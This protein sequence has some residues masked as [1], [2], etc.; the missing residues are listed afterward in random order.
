MSGIFEELEM[1][2]EGDK[3]VTRQAIAAATKRFNDNFAGFLRQA[4]T[5]KEFNNRLALVDTDI[6]NMVADVVTEY[7]GDA[8]KI[9]SAVK[10]TV[11]TAFAP[12]T[13]AANE[14][15]M[16]E[17]CGGHGCDKCTNDPEASK[18]ASEDRPEHLEAQDEVQLAEE[19]SQVNPW[20]KK[21]IQDEDQEDGGNLRNKEAA[22]DKCEECDCEP[23][24]CDKHKDKTAN[25]EDSQPVANPVPF[26]ETEGVGGNIEKKLESA[27]SAVGTGKPEIPLNHREEPA[28]P[29]PNPMPMQGV[30]G[31]ADT[32][33]EKEKVEPK[34][35]HE[36]SETAHEEHEEHETAKEK[37]EEHKKPSGAHTV[38]KK[39]DKFV[40]V[41]DGGEEAAGPF[42]SK[43]K[44]QARAKELNEL[45]NLEK[46][47]AAFNEAEQ[48][49]AARSNLYPESG[50]VKV[51]PAPKKPTT[52]P[53]CNGEGLIRNNTPI[54]KQHQAMLNELGWDAVDESNVP[55]YRYYY[56]PCPNCAD[57]HSWEGSGQVTAT[58]KKALALKEAAARG[59]KRNFFSKDEW[60]NEGDTVTEDGK[61]KKVEDIAQ[62]GDEKV[63]ELSDGSVADIDDVE[64]AGSKTA[65]KPETGDKTEEN[66]SLPTGNEDAH[67]GPSPKIDKTK[68]KPNATNPDGNLKP[69]DTEGENSPVPTRQMDIKQKPDYQQDTLENLEK[70]DNN[71][72]ER[73]ELPTAT[74]DEAGFE[75]TRNIEQLPTK[76]FP[77]KGQ[78]DPVT[79]EA[80]SY[81]KKVAIFED[82]KEILENHVPKDWEPW[83][84]WWNAMADAKASGVSEDEIRDLWLSSWRVAQDP[85]TLERIGITPWRSKHPE[86]NKSLSD[87]YGGSTSEGE[88]INEVDESP[89]E[90]ATEVIDDEEL[91]REPNIDETSE[92]IDEPFVEEIDL[93]ENPEK[94]E[95]IIERGDDDGDRVEV[96]EEIEDEDEDPLGFDN[97]EKLELEEDDEDLD[98]PFDEELSEKELDRLLEEEDKKDYND[99]D[100][101]L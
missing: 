39:G 84:G 99:E 8:D 76:T 75:G 73:E 42:N 27:P 69:I 4:S 26:A 83:H 64:V 51:S 12:T 43:E 55:V 15:P 18:T 44:A 61:E 29:I 98:L 11:K 17:N 57:E 92:D 24:E 5:E 62:H 41:E 13:P 91:S 54:S 53:S 58:M 90:V 33:E 40:V 60:V 66:E 68:W 71:I 16:C 63:V 59:E 56:D 30:Y 49:A 6:N 87:E 67:D 93:V 97:P 70:Y 36:K 19:H 37:K 35:K 50:D 89:L 1:F 82:E 94:I 2:D 100:L 23:C 65:A 52:C 3:V 85:E 32:T 77:D 81:L 9:A 88:T 22:S 80:L 14:Y 101:F 31:A 21:Q 38:E 96:I 10:E 86:T 20:L 72:W 79:R 95:E 78:T 46:E 74:E 34:A 28:D 25:I 45:E 7:G 48:E 47:A